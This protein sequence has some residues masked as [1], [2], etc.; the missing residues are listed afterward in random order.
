MIKVVIIKKYNTCQITKTLMIV[1]F[2]MFALPKTNFIFLHGNK[3]IVYIKR[4]LF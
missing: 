1:Y 3:Y 4:D 2:I